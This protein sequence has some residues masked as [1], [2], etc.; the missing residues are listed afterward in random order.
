MAGPSKNCFAV[1]NLRPF[2]IRSNSMSSI[3]FGSNASLTSCRPML[4]NIALTSGNN[5]SIELNRFP[6]QLKLARLLF[7]LDFFR[8]SISRLL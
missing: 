5:E 8:N 7:F 6:W 1:K 3:S 4:L 2:F